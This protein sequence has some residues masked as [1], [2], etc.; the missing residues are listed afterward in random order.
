MFSFI[1]GTNR[2]LS[3]IAKYTNDE[4]Y[5]QVSSTS[6][7]DKTTKQISNFRLVQQLNIIDDM[8]RN[9]LELFFDEKIIR[10]L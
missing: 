3:E 5:G 8:K 7:G 4:K 1:F 9:S 10:S 6:H 2:P